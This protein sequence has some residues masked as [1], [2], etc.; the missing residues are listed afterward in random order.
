MSIEGILPIGRRVIDMPVEEVATLEVGKVIHPVR[1]TVTVAVLVLAILTGSWW[2]VVPGVVIALWIVVVAF[3]PN[4][5]PT[6]TSGDRETTAIC[7]GHQ[8]DGE[9]HRDAVWA[10]A[11]EHRSRRRERRRP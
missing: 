3:G 8:I 10:I 7:L 2:I 1:L 9:F 11:E 5:I 6:T 4:L